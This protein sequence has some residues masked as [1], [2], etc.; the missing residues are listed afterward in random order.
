MAD[1]LKGKKTLNV[2]GFLDE[3]EKD[4]VKK[5]IDI[6]ELFNHFNIQLTKKGKNHIGL[7]P[8]HKDSNPSL[9]VDRDK[10]LYNCFGC[11]ES[12]DIF[13]LVEK[14]KGFNFKESLAFLKSY[15]KKQPLKIVVKNGKDSEVNIT[16]EKERETGQEEIVTFNDKTAEDKNKTKSEESGINKNNE[17]EEFEETEIKESKILNIVTD[18]YHKKLLENKEALT[19]LKQRGLKKPSLLTRFKIGFCDGTILD[20]VS[21]KDQKKL[22][23]IGILNE[24]SREHFFNCITFPILEDNQ[25]TKGIYGRKIK[26]SPVPHLYLKGKHSGIF[27]SKVSKIYD[28]IILTE[29]IIDA[30]SL[31]ETGLENVQSLY[32]TNGLTEFHLKRLKDDRVKEI[33]IALD[34]D[35]PGKIASEKLKERFIAEDFDV[36]IIYP[37]NKDWNADL[38]SPY[39]GSPQNPPEGDLQENWPKILKDSVEE[40]INKAPTFANPHKKIKPA[41]AKE[42]GNYVFTINEITYRVSGVKD[43]F[44]N[45]LRVNV[46]AMLRLCPAAG[47]TTEEKFY[48]NLDL[49]SSRSRASYSMSLSKIFDVEPARVEKDLISIL[50]YLEE[51]RDRKLNPDPEKEAEKMT[52]EEIALGMQLLTSEDIYQEI[53]D[54]MTTLGYVGEEENK[55]LVWLAGISRLASKPLSVFIQS[56][57]STGKSF[58]LEILLKLLPESSAEWITSMSDQAFNYMAEEDFLDKIFMLGEALHN[59]IIEGYIRQMQSENRI[60]RK[61]TVKDPKSGM[62]KTTTVKHDVRLGFMQT[63]TAMR[64]NIENLS[65]CL[66]LKVDASKEQTEKVQAMQ[67]FKA[68]YEG[69][70]EE[71]HIVPEII[72]KHIAAQKL[73]KKI[74]VFNPFENYIRFPST[75]SVMR[76]GQTQFLGL[77]HASCVGRQMQKKPVEKLDPYTGELEQVFECDLTDYEKVRSLFING[78]LLQQD[79]D[80]SSSV[81]KLYENIR[82]LVVERG[83]KE[84]IEPESISFIQSEVREITCLGHE[85]VKRY[86]RILVE[87]EYI[88]IVSGRRH[89]T[90]FGYKLR[91]NKPI[92]QVDIS[93]IIPTVEEIKAMLEKEG[94]R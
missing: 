81:I 26:E 9:S 21:T 2:T 53:I 24:K 19:Y 77:L 79:E 38:V 18:Y 67:R 83:K 22:T 43:V 68:S 93:S 55:L 65:R 8:W 32:G 7:C 23:G 13:T 76:R 64:V 52:E 71:K 90:K 94:K 89:G 5:N 35:E 50:E 62:M 36:K 49:Y 31:I 41:I 16:D 87:Y 48:D 54:D 69:Y 40:K 4:D 14:M 92:S 75:R 1:R 20:K 45:N 42:H 28:A 58:L 88:Q 30:L 3:F 11:G 17:K 73:L 86:M 66:V 44:V 33:I 12:G 6:T 63:S 85:S 60:S 61:V 25:N 39:V 78:K 74:P 70:L 56:P 91:E 34:N 80:L 47:D 84:N 29:S 82:N 57:A 59:D 37:D 15:S 10:G 27:N 46:K 51:E 72:K